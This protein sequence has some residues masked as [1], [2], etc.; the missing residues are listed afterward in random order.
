MRKAA[1]ALLA[2]PI[3][4]AVYVGAVVA[5]LD[6]WPGPAS[7]SA[8]HSSSV[9][10]SSAP[11]TRRPPSPTPPT[12][13]VPLTAG[14]LHDGR[15]PRI[16]ASL[17]PVTIEFSTPM[18]RASVAS[19]VSV[20]P[21]TQVDARLGR[22]RHRA[23]D[24][25]AGRTGPPGRSTPSPSRPVPSPQSG[26]PLA[27]PARAAF[28]TRDADDRVGRRHGPARRLGSRSTRRSSITFARPVDP[29]TVPAGD[30]AGPADARHR[31][32]SSL[33]TDG[34]TRYTFV[35]SGAAPGGRRPTAS[36]VSGVRDVD[37]VAA[38]HADPHR[39]D[40]RRAPAVVRFRPRADTAD[41]AR[42][43]AISV[44]FTESMDRRSTAAAFAVSVGGK[45]IAGKVR[46]AEADTVLVFAPATPL[47]YGD[48]RRHGRRRPARE[49]R[50]R[51]T[52]WRCPA[53]ARSRRSPSR[54]PPAAAPSE[55][56]QRVR[57]EAVAAVRPSVAAAGRA[58]ET[59]Y[60][61]PHEL[62]PDRR[63]GHLGRARAAARAA[64]TSPPLRLDSGISTK[65]SR[66]YAKLL[67][68]GADCSHFIGGNP[69][70]RLRRAGLHE[71]PLGG[72]H[73]L[74][75]GQPRSSAVLGLAPVLPEREVVQR[76][77]LRQPDERGVRPRRHRC[78]GVRRPGPPR[79]RLLPP[80]TGP[81]AG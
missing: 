53:T 10:A 39:P 54:R 42:D 33:P 19:A 74:P 63:L 29:A 28:L 32:R 58:V 65:V 55:D 26:Q 21:P 51:R 7:P 72:E 67:A 79:G 14:G 37:G 56:Q 77:P 9:S 73:R 12:A 11:A 23:D 5:T 27:R 1:I 44:R 45:P 17:E 57:R 52:R 2:V 43:A 69:G 59:Y 49:Q 50:R 13:I 3:I 62:H 20:E 66:P 76:R 64:A 8:W 75:L 22:E 78:L 24:L 30:P 4:V 35:P 60:L 6:A 61:R 34:A 48:D 41:V 80:L 36:I 40:R 70:D 25:P 71:L 46:W 18:D 81:S 15:S 68:V 16:V 31:S 47:P 38:R